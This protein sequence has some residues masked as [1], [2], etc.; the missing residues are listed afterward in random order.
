MST[1][2]SATR[3]STAQ[4]TWRVAADYW[5]APSGAALPPDSF[6][7]D[8]TPLIR[9]E[10]IC[11]ALPAYACRPP[12]FVKMFTDPT[13]FCNEL[14]G[15]TL[16]RDIASITPSIRVPDLLWAVEA[17]RAVITELVSAE[18][19]DARL[20][21]AYLALPTWWLST[22]KGLG[23][24]LNAYHRARRP[25]T[26]R[27]QSVLEHHVGRIAGLL[28]TCGPHL[29]S[30]W[31]STA[32]DVLER[33]HSSLAH[34][35]PVLVQSHGDLSLGNLLLGNRRVYVVDF[36]YSGPS[37]RELDLIILRASL[38]ASLGHRPF[39]GPARV[40]LW[41]AFI[42]GYGPDAWARRDREASDLLELHILAFN[43]AR[44]S[45]Q[46]S[47]VSGL[48]RLRQTYKRA[49]MRGVLRRWLAERDMQH[50]A[51]GIVGQ[52]GRRGACD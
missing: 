42:R 33:V 30:P 24:W 20:Q 13:L 5:A 47:S 38:L 31:L 40:A 14:D 16:A 51:G 35:A 6:A 23:E 32:Y 17:E 26:A 3:P 4:R 22:F 45:R 44:L 43:L 18:P 28:Q 1:L 2:P 11:A 49:V 9:H 41:S 8:V 27:H 19:I 10:A 21:R 25:D 37:Y 15:L 48:A 39:S 36:A 34:R 50:A 12:G 29:G 46:P 52:N 7:S